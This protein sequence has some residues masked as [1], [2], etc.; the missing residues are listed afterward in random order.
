MKA[1]N[2][3]VP[4]Q[5]ARRVNGKHLNIFHDLLFFGCPQDPTRCRFFTWN[6]GLETSLSIAG[7]AG[8]EGGGGGGSTG[9][10]FTCGQTGWVL[11]ISTQDISAASL[12]CKSVLQASTQEALQISTQ[13]VSAA[14]SCC[15]S[16]LQ[17]S[18]Q[19]VSAASLC[20]KLARRICCK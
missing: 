6:D 9:P 20:C 19:D 16:V 5:G 10:C 2:Q 3:P 12:C 17:A 1:S 8:G 14:S 11:Q 15:K 13:V 7:G 18:T 4:C